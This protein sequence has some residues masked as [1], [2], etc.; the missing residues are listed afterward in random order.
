MKN[1]NKKYNFSVI[2]VT[3]NPDDRAF[4]SLQLLIDCCRECDIIIVDN[5]CTE[6]IMLDELLEKE[7]VSI[8]SNKKNMGIAYAQNSGLKI[9]KQMGYHW[10]I[11]LDQD[12]KVCKRLFD[13]YNEFLLSVELLNVGIL[14]SDYYDVGTGKSKYGNNEAIE[15]DE[16][17]SSGSLINLDIC[18]EIGWMKESY[19]IDQV[20][21][22]Y[23]YRLKKNRY[24]ILLLPGEDMEHKL[25]NITC[26]HLYKFSFY[27]YNQEPSRTYYRTRNSLFM[28]REYG[29]NDKDLVRKKIKSILLDFVR[30][31][32]EKD[33]LAKYI[34]FFKGIFDGMTKKW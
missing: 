18:Y 3:Y 19:F 17:I 15:I 23:C 5:S 22:E 10:A 27:I 29:K 28:M 1:I 33:S 32:Y 11:T 6:N 14:C 7:N 25:G 8:I 4:D 2:V 21:N 24:K 20:D 9:S 31:I 13:K 16:A 34:N 12:T 26:M 30:I